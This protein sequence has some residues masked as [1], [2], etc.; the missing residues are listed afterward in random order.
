MEYNINDILIE[1]E[2]INISSLPGPSNETETSNVIQ[3]SND[4]N[5]SEGKSLSLNWKIFC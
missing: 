2:G 4:D 3:E 5:E 1:I